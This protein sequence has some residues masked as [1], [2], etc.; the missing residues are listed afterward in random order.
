MKN[1]NAKFKVEFKKRIYN[2][3]LQL[4]KFIDK[5]SRDSV[6]SVMS[7]QLLRSGTS[8]LANYIEANESLGKNDFY[9]RLKI[10]RKE[11]KESIMWLKLTIPT[12]NEDKTQKHLIVEGTEIMK[13]FGSIITKIYKNY[14]KE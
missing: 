1:D 3:V 13:I 4:I 10:C 14:S 11:M 12:G 5:L 6:C 7:K 9:M 2:K 8:V